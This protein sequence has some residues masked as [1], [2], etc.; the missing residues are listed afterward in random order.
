[1]SVPPSMSYGILFVVKVLLSCNADSQ[2]NGR[3][4]SF[5]VDMMIVFFG[6]EYEISRFGFDWF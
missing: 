6:N 4:V 2:P 5:D 1:M 3:L